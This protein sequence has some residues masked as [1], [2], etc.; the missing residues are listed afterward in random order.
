[1]PESRSDANG[2]PG[3][4]TVPS[5]ICGLD[6]TARP[7]A[8]WKLRQRQLPEPSDKKRPQ[9]PAAVVMFAA[10]GRIKLVALC[11]SV[12]APENT[13]YFVMPAAIV[14]RPVIVVVPVIVRNWDSFVPKS[15]VVALA[16]VS[17]AIV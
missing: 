11:V 16:M 17:L 8:S 4:D 6:T 12:S 10:P 5:D 13:T 1:M 7:L 9:S 15:V 14:P 2:M 3:S